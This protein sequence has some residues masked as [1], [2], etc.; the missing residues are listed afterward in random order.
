[1]VHQH[2]FRLRC[3]TPS[4]CISREVDWAWWTRHLASTLPASRS[5][6]FLLMDPP[7]IAS[8]CN[9][10]GYNGRSHIRDLRRYS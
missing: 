1:M 2:V 6:G 5:F 7:E 4:C 8:V 10:G 3:E 9:T